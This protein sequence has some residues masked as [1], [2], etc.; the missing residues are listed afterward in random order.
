M[1]LHV[2]AC[3]VGI[4]I[5]M[6]VCVLICM[7]ICAYIVVVSVCA[8][9][10]VHVHAWLCVR[11]V[12][13]TRNRRDHRKG[14]TSSTLDHNI[15]SVTMVIDKAKRR[16]HGSTFMHTML[17]NAPLERIRRLYAVRHQNTRRGYTCLACQLHT[18]GL[19]WGAAGC[20]ANTFSARENSAV[21][22]H[23]PASCASRNPR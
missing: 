7:C 9:T 2:A 8:R 14:Q 23:E 19:S 18:G 6:C 1:S 11:R 21:S 22:H 16:S 5:C 17:C 12:P 3:R 15:P 10:C 4:C 13:S 20:G